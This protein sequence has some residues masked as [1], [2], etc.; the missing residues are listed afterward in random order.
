LGGARNGYCSIDSPLMVTTPS[1]T[2]RIEMTIATMGRRMKK[3]AT[4]YFPFE[5]P[6]DFVPFTS[7]GGFVSAGP[8]LARVGV[9]LPPGR[10]F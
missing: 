1:S 8:L 5:S 10:A 7:P 9:T 3:F 4:D 2:V 6:V